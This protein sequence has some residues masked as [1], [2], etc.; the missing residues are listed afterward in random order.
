MS[1]YLVTTN[2]F[3]NY[4]KLLIS[5]HIGASNLLVVSVDPR[6]GL[7]IVSLNPKFYHIIHRKIAWQEAQAILVG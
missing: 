4:E 5:T 3:F 7:P 2:F 1:I 6:D